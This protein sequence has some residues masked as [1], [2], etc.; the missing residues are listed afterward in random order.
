M[1][2]NICCAQSDQ[3]KLNI[4]ILYSRHIYVCSKM[5][6]LE[7]LTPVSVKEILCKYDSTKNLTIKIVEYTLVF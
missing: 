6:F 5:S 7:Y 2:L 4:Y 3:S 1:T